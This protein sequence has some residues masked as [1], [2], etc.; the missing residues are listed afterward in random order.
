MSISQQP[1]KLKPSK[2]AWFFQLSFASGLIYAVFQTLNMCAGFIFAAL[3]IFSLWLSFYLYPK[4]TYFCYLGDQVWTLKLHNKQK[5]HQAQLLQVIG[6]RLYIVL[7][8]D[9][10]S[11]LKPCVIWFDQLPTADWKRLKVLAQLH[12]PTLRL[13]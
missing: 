8:W 3:L 13:D 10:T 1:F 4:Y 6:H 12:R 2:I 7:Y 9:K 5:L 11:G